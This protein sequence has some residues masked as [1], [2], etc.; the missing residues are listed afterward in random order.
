MIPR[1]GANKPGGESSKVH[2]RISQGTNKPG[3]NE[4]VAKEP[5]ANRLGGETAK[6]RQSHKPLSSADSTDPQITPIR[7]SAFRKMHQPKYNN[8]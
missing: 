8:S 7:N 4:P 3:A 2:G 1:T 6:G 5:G